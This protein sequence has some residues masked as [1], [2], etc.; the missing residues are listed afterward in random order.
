L[1]N[2]DK[3]LPKVAGEISLFAA[4][5]FVR[6]YRLA[7][8]PLHDFD[9]VRNYQIAKEIAAG[10]FA[11]VNTHGSPIF[12]LLN[13]M[14]FYF[15]G[16]AFVLLA[17]GAI[18][19]VAAVFVFA[20]CAGYFLKEILPEKNHE[21]ASALFVLVCGFS[22]LLVYLSRCITNENLNFFLYSLLFYAYLTRQ[23][24]RLKAVLICACFAV[25]Y[26]I[27]LVLPF[28]EAAFFDDFQN[29]FRRAV[30]VFFTFL[31]FVLVFSVFSYAVGIGAENYLKN[32]AGIFLN[33]T[34]AAHSPIL[35]TDFWF[36]LRYGAEIDFFIPL[37]MLFAVSLFAAKMSRWSASFFFFLLMLHFLPKAPR[38]L[39]YFLPVLVLVAIG[40]FAEFF[41]KKQKYKP[42]L[43][44]L[45]LI[46]AFLPLPF[47]LYAC[48][49]AHAQRENFSN[50]EHILTEKNIEKIF[51]LN[52][53]Q[54]APYLSKELIRV[55]EGHQFGKG[56]VVFFDHYHKA[57]NEFKN[58]DFNEFEV[59]YTG[60]QRLYLSPFLYY[61]HAEYSGLR[62]AE[63]Q[64][65]ES[66][67]KWYLLQ[68]K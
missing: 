61:E 44:S 14:L 64:I 38:A 42:I 56:D 63:I 12:H 52:S 33:K 21:L 1:K 6:L 65:E 46:F 48:I 58:F 11:H 47:R 9:A 27:L 28:L 43:L 40:V 22:P 4:L 36:Y 19:N 13:G 17:T 41:K 30:R 57:L 34:R 3:L 66:Y 26:K 39:L 59:L 15:S 31:L 16:E 18:L 51:S 24:D 32:V 23:E 50:V 54:A 2:P 45:F 29:S 62:F 35:N 5:L 68:K 55:R 49:Y 67:A 20:K 37:L 8:I 7:D 25:N 53:L 60:E 10:N